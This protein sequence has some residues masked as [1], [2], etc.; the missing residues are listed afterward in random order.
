MREFKSI[1]MAS[2]M[3]PQNKG[4]SPLEIIARLDDLTIS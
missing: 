2:R 1:F 4:N 3:I